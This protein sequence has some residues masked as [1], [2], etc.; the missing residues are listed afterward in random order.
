MPPE[1]CE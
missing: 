1:F